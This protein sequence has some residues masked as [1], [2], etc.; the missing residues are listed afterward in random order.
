MARVQGPG[1]VGVACDLLLAWRT[2]ADGVTAQTSKTRQK[3]WKHWT[4]YCHQCTT[5]PYLDELSSCERAVLITAFAARV[6]TGAYG[7][8]DQV[9]V[10]TV[11]KALA[12]I[13][14]TCQLVGKQSP[15][16]QTE[17]KYILPVE[18]IVEGF[19][20]Q[21]PPA[22]PQMA[23]PKDVPE[24]ALALAYAVGTNRTEAVGDL[25]IV[26]FYYLLRSG[27]YTKPRKVKR[28]GIMVRATRTVQF[29]VKDVGFWKDGKI[30]PRR[31]SLSA[32][33]QADAATMKITNQK[34]GRTGQT[35]HHESTGPNGAVA[36]LARRTHH[37]LSNTGSE[38]QLICDVCE[39]EAW[40]SVTSTEIVHAVR[41]AAKSLNLQ[42]KGI[43]PDMIGAHSL[44]AG[45]AMA[46]KIMGE[47]DSTIR[48]FGRWT[49]DTWMMYIHSQIS[50]LYKGVAQKM[51][52]PIDYHN[53]AF[54]EPML[55][56]EQ[57]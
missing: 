23:V 49:S 9:G 36:A 47:T 38:N 27:E 20:R 35:L 19:K 46:L 31:S 44:R 33:L 50:Q 10:Q 41:Q 17:G 29:K 3:Y 4:E 5:D 7:R 15:V 51:S 39:D 13:S 2:I 14:K 54:I 8:G 24:A 40:T 53:I 1:K 42:E 37:I 32:L 55:V 21:D 30:L 11:T 6:R 28:N 52:T 26:A 45:G 56:E 34:N 48:K 43:D 18:R 57:Q 22:I 16:T 12:A 25:T